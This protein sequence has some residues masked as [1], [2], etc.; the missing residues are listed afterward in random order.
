MG[1]VEIKDTFYVD[2][3]PLKII[4]GAFHYSGRC[5]NTGRIGWRS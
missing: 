2:G 3:E 5:R 4:S 1:S